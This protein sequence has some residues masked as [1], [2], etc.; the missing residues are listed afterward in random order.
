MGKNGMLPYEWEWWH[1]QL[2][3]DEY[4]KSNYKLLDF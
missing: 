3:Y 1:F 2:D 4:S